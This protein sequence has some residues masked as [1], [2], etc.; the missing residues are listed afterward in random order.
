[1][2][3]FMFIICIFTVNKTINMEIMM[4][5]MNVGQEPTELAPKNAGASYCEQAWTHQRCVWILEPALG[6]RGH[7][8]PFAL[9]HR[10]SCAQ[11]WNDYG[12]FFSTT[13][14]QLGH[15][16]K[17]PISWSYFYQLVLCHFQPSKHVGSPCLSTLVMSV[18]LCPRLHIKTQQI[19]FLQLKTC[20]TDA[21]D[22]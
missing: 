19:T 2:H 1:M 16:Q 21:F 8:S 17:L 20:T 22:K 14:I 4:K 6:Q 5:L 18:I 7:S 13:T 9:I 10:E 3:S 15:F 12:W 11:Q